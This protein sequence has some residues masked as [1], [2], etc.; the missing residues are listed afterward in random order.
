MS[1]N[2]VRSVPQQ[3]RSQ[4][5]VDAILD[6]A[7]DVFTQV[8]YETATTNAI[9]ERAGISIGSLY[10]YFSDKDAILRALATRY[11]QEEQELL[12]K[13]LTDDVVYLPL[14]VL[15]DRMIDPF[16][17]MYCAC[18]VYAHILLGMDVSADIA[19][20]S[21][22]SEREV[23]ERL[24][25][26]LQRVAPQVDAHQASLTAVICKAAVKSLISLR[27]SPSDE[28]FQA[29]ITAE[30]KRMLLAYLNTVLGSGKD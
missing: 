20:A 13:V 7:A 5:R 15:L 19:A 24:T 17:E 10:R 3:S 23:I 16:L 22:E 29:Q 1:D 30:V 2:S 9:A 28:G 4:Q 6:T 18:P 12:D 14:P 8:G 11:H 26:I 27:S 21:Q 25:G